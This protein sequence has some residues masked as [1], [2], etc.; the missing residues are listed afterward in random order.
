MLAAFV[1]S[2]LQSNPDSL[3]NGL[4]TGLEMNFRAI[5]I[6]IGFSAI[7]KELY[8]PKIIRFF[9]KSSNPQLLLAL[10][11][12]FQSVPAAIASLPNVKSFLRNPI[13]AIQYLIE[14]ADRQME[15]LKFHS[16]QKSEIF[17]ITGKKAQGKTTFI[18]QLIEILKSKNMHIA[19]F[20]SKRSM[21]GQQTEGYDVVD[22]QS[23]IAYPF[24]RNDK[25]SSSETIGKFS[26]LP[27]GYQ[28]AIDLLSNLNNSTQKLVVI[29]EVGKLELNGK[30]WSKELD[31]LSKE[32]FHHV[33]I[34]VRTDF[35]EEVIQRW[36]FSNA[37]IFDITTCEIYDVADKIS[38]TTMK[39]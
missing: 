12:S 24:L 21:Q 19:G 16:I 22:I 25:L 31:R 38:K 36:N 4:I 32:Q 8:N 30:G 23:G 35:L 2:S 6:I 28:K 5:V 10:E 33:L 20:Y 3:K 9:Q 17:I 18:I 39:V 15:T 11:L 13:L 1:F 26:V 37:V 14:N 7:G 29:D 34:S 27:E